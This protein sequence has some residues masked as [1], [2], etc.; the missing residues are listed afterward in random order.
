M[1]HCSAKIASRPHASAFCLSAL[2]CYRQR[3]PSTLPPFQETLPSMAP[4]QGSPRS[5]FT[6]KSRLPRAPFHPWRCCCKCPRNQ[7]HCPR[8]PAFPG[9]PS[10]H[11]ASPGISTVNFYGEIAPPQGA[12]PSMA[13]LLQVPPRSPST[14]GTHL[15][16]TK[17]LFLHSTDGTHPKL[18][19]LRSRAHHHHVPR[20]LPHLTKSLSR[21][22]RA[23]V[24]AS[25]S[26]HLALDTTS[27]PA[28]PREDTEVQCQCFYSS[29]PRIFGTGQIG[30][31][32]TFISSTKGTSSLV[33]RSLSSCAG[34]VFI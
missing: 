29:A 23:E 26:T 10:I 33:P 3:A 2:V 31:N 32:S 24:E 1:M 17:R 25:A 21:S 30:T 20:S 16:S 8:D 14:D 27:L 34:M 15:P 22:S 28:V 13:S 18:S 9:C 12:L 5:I 11:G 6:E 4:P 7:L 19:P